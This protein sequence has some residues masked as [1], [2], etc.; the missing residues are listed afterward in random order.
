MNISKKAL[1]CLKKKGIREIRLSLFF[2]CSIKIKMEFNKEESG[3][4]LDFEGI[5]IVADE[6]TL[7]FLEGLMIDLSDEGLFLRPE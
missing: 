6:D 4:G 7:L 3:E 5:K 1:N 2:D